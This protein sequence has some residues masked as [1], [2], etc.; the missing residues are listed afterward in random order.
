MLMAA[1]AA[2]QY[3]LERTVADILDTLFNKQHPPVRATNWCD[4]RGI[5]KVSNNFLVQF[6]GAIFICA[7]FLL[8]FITIAANH[9]A[10]P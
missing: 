8:I 10:Y 9:L 4:Q 6:C 5:P 2:Q 1:H 7:R 3:Q